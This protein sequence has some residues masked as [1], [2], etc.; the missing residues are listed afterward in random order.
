VSHV[1]NESGFVEGGGDIFLSKK[2]EDYHEEMKAEH[3]ERHMVENVFPKIR[4]SFW[5]SIMRRIT[6]ELK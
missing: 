5:S 6:L 2:S 1:G 4:D 3:Y